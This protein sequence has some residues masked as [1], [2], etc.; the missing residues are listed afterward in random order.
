MEK[1]GAEVR[2]CPPGGIDCLRSSEITRAEFVT[3]LICTDDGQKEL[4]Y[5]E[6]N[7]AGTVR[8]VS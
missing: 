6:V 5:G 7:V 8:L 4:R 3:V 2:T 1:G